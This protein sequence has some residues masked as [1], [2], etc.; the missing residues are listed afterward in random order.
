M[1]GVLFHVILIL[2]KLARGYS[3]ALKSFS[4]MIYPSFLIFMKYNKLFTFENLYNSHLKARLSKRDKQEV[5]DFELDSGAN[6]SKLFY[7][8]KYFK[9][10]ISPYNT[11]YIYEPK[12]RRLDALRYRDRIVQHCLCDYYLTPLYDK[13]LIYDNAAT[14]IGKGTDFAR[15][16]L[17]YFYYDFYNKNHNNQGYVLKCDIHHFFECIDHNVL[18]GILS[19]DIKDKDIL[20]LLYKIIDSYSFDINKGLPIGNQTSQIFAIRYLD[21]L[22]RI[23]KEK[24]RIKYYIRYMDDFI[25]VHESKDY[26]KKIL[27]YITNLLKDEF[28]LEL[29]KKT[30]IYKLSESVEFLGFSY[31]LLNNQKVLMRLNGVRRKRFLKKMKEKVYQY[32]NKTIDRKK[33]NETFNSYLEH[34]SK[35]NC[36]SFRCRIKYLK[37]NK[38]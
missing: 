38:R 18:K 26:L 29:N 21:K 35:G 19:Q 1:Q 23:I 7:E 34:A 11:F 25:L 16:R 6:I 10:N 13:R 33:L 2:Q 3:N 14:R 15:K 37:K 17:K 20:N 30:R 36:N 32:K 22:D 27:E 28:K 31:R 4:S 8:L 9:Y 5:I 12:E 24:F